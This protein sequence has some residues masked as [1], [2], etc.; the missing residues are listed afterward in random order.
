[1][2]FTNC[3]PSAGMLNNVSLKMYGDCHHKKE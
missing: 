1:M 3:I 2:F